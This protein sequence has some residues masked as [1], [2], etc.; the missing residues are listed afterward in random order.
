LGDTWTLVSTEYTKWK[1]SFFFSVPS[2]PDKSRKIPERSK[3]CYCFTFFS[4]KP[5]NHYLNDSRWSGQG[6]RLRKTERKKE[7]NF[8]A[9]SECFKGSYNLFMY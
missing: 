3:L 7:D 6:V 9:S 1:F 4:S 2:S 8:R 5:N